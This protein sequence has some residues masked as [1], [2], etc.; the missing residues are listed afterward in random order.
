MFYTIYM[1]KKSKILIFVLV[2]LC[3]FS[4]YKI[5][6]MTLEEIELLV[7]AG[8][9]ELLAKTI[10]KPWEGQP[11]KTGAVGGTWL[12]SITSD[13]KSFN[14]LIAER[15]AETNGILAHFHEYLVDYDYVK[16]E[17]KPQAAYFKIVVDETAQKLSVYYTLRDDLYWSYYRNGKIERIMKVTSDDVIFWYN[18]IE[19]DPA[20][21]SSAYNSQFVVLED[22]SL[23]HIDIEKID[24]ATFAFHFPRI[25]ANPLLSTNRTFGP[26]FLYE[27]AKKTHGVKGVED[28]LSINTKPE[29]I[30]SMGMWLLKEYTPGQRLV[31]VR[32]ADYWN[33]DSKGNAIPYA[34]EK[35]LQIVPDQNTQYLLFQQD[36]LEA[37]SPKPEE[38]DEVVKNQKDYRVF[39][40]GG[41]LGA[42]M[43]SFNQ[44]PKNSHAP[45]YAWFTKKEFRQAMSCL[46]HRDRIIS[47]TYRGLAEP[48]LD[49]FPEANPYYNKDIQLDYVYN[50]ERAKKLLAQIGIRQNSQG[51]MIDEKGNP[52]EFDLT[53]VSDNSIANDIAS[54]IADECKKIGIEVKIRTLDFQ[55]VVEQLTTS[56]DW[57]SVII[58]LGANYWPTQGSN[59]WPSDG[60]LHL[61]YPLQEKPATAWEARIDYLY[62]EGSFTIDKHKAQKIWDEYQEILLEQCPMIYLVRPRSFFALKNRWD[63]DNFYYD[64]IGGSQ[65]DHLYLKN[66]MMH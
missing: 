30:P 16:K 46:L 33:K 12:S 52:V 57:Q 59:V 26:R 61:W 19:G 56:Y 32:N 17:F 9:A 55:K 64:T 47:Q 45:Y 39:N 41:S 7:P 29:D 51:I 27:K 10:S 5:P 49:F 44:N 63:F 65:V 13:P 20:F 4:C 38:L 60:N 25:D 58:G 40:A 35:V 11:W 43:W 48:K 34:Q 62:N 15:D 36:K 24:D 66:E 31:F 28:L 2:C 3:V 50:P 54:I 21:R 42:S 22:G 18:E 37:Y 8:T 23:A 53:I 14:L 1:L 6:E